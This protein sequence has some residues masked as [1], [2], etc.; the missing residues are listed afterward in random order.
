MTIVL[1][2][3]S[4]FRTIAFPPVLHEKG[5]VEQAAGFFLG[6]GELQIVDCDLGL[7]DPST[8]CCSLYQEDCACSHRVWNRFPAI[9]SRAVSAR[10]AAGRSG[11]RRGRMAPSLL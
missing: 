3:R 5:Q 7:S 9:V 2:W 10:G 11:R 4:V 6:L 8:I 1:R